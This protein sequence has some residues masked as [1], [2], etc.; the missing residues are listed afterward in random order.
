MYQLMRIS[1]YHEYGPC[2]CKCVCAST[3]GAIRSKV[4]VACAMSVVTHVHT[5]HSSLPSHVSYFWSLCIR[6]EC[7]VCTYHSIQR[8]HCVHGTIFALQA[9][10]VRNITFISIWY[11]TTRILCTLC[12]RAFFCIIWSL[13]VMYPMYSMNLQTSM[14]Y[15]YSLFSMYSRYSMY[16]VC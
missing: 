13:Y 8:M 3:W 16:V 2:Y 10:S 15:M 11:S 1:V 9:L 14:Y 6:I 4:H 12:M 5:M 7:V